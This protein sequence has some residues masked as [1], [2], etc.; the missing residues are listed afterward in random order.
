MRV[1]FEPS[2]RPRRL[3]AEVSN[4]AEATKIISQF[5][6]D[7]KYKSGYWRFWSEGEE[8]IID[9]GSWTEFF[10]LTD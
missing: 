2:G 9:V 1:Y 8:T 3:L 7:H 5:L 6:E 4:R 10:I